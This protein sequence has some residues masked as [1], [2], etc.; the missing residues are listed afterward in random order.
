MCPPRAADTPRSE[1]RRRHAPASLR[2]VHVAQPRW[3]AACQLL[4]KSKPVPA[5]EKFLFQELTAEEVTVSADTSP[6]G[7]A[8]S[9]R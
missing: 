1:S 5:T 3:E 4:T 6:C 8:H 9:Q 7:F 2:T